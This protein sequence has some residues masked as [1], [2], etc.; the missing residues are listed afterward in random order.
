MAT[1]EQGAWVK[2]VLGIAIPTGGTSPLNPRGIAYPMLLLRWQ[3]AQD[4]AIAAL[5]QLGDSL[6][7]MEEVKLDP[8]L[9]RVKAAVARL[10][11]LVPDLGGKLRDLL[12]A[13]INAGSDTAIATE[14]LAVVAEYRS[15]LAA[16]TG[17]ARIEAFARKHVGELGAL[18]TLD[19][20]LGEI[21]DNLAKAI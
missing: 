20:T 11:T 13:G 10:P 19:G 8:R 4:S 7:G 17:L 16:A 3:T 5:R 18:R 12:D 15:R 21:A 6:L 1:E 2:R 9:P 14:A